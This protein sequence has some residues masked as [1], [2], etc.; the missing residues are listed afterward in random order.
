MRVLGNIKAFV[1]MEKDG[2]VFKSTHGP[3]T[4][5]LDYIIALYVIEL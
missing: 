2:E 4:W 1:F 5:K 3:C